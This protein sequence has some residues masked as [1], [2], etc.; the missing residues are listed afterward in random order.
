MVSL[1]GKFTK[2][3]CLQLKEGLS[4][5]LSL[6]VSINPELFLSVILTYR[7]KSVNYLGKMMVHSIDRI[8]MCDVRVVLDFG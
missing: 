7:K 6:K 5:L 8:T 2:K 3:N 1:P 4:Y